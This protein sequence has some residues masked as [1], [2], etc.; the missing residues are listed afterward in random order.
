[1][2][3]FQ[4]ITIVIGSAIS[5]IGFFITFFNY[6]SK[7][8]IKVDIEDYDKKIT[9]LIKK[10]YKEPLEKALYDMKQILSDF[11]NKFTALDTIVI[12]T[13]DNKFTNLEKQIDEIKKDIEKIENKMDKFNSI[14][15]D[16]INNNTVS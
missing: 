5:I 7:K 9:E 1:M 8:D 14:L 16:M 12:S 2:T 15:I 3:N 13:H 11:N 6:K 4:I 10:D